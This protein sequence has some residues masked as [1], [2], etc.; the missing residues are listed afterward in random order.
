MRNIVLSIMVILMFSLTSVSAGLLDDLLK[1][2]TK[3][4][5]ET[6]DEGTIIS[7][8]K[9]AL[10][11]GTDK[12]VKNVSLKDGYFGNSAI[13]ILMPENIQKVADIL[14]KTGFQRQV[15]DFILSMNRAAEKAAPKATSFFIAAVKE[16]TF[17]EARKILNGGDTAATEYFKGKTYNKLYESFKPSVSS[18]MN[19]VGVARS[20][21]RMMSRYEAIPF[22]EKQSLDIDHYVT[23]KALDGLFYM[24]GQEEKKIRTDPTARVTELLKAVFGK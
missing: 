1:G 23:A 24:V 7:G 5:K 8:L 14:R 11:I 9:E 21:K 12:A 15:D 10:T 22:V 19:D 4:S 20:Y 16:M 13:K 3:P 2:V 17:E 6:Q 18:S